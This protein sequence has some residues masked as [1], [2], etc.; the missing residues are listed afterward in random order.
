MKNATKITVASSILAALASG[1]VFAQASVQ[2][3]EFT[4]SFTGEVLR[5]ALPLDFFRAAKVAKCPNGADAAFS[6]GIMKC[7]VDVAHFA[8]VVCGNTAAFPDYVAIAS[9]ANA[10]ERDVCTANTP[11]GNQINSSTNLAETKQEFKCD[12]G[13]T[14]ANHSTGR[15]CLNPGVSISQN[16]ALSGFSEGRNR[17]YY[18]PTA[19]TVN[20][21]VRGT[22]YEV[23][24]PGG[25]RGE[26]S[27]VAGVA[28]ANVSEQGWRLDVSQPGATDKFKRIVKR[29]VDPILVNP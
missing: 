3:R 25:V 15:I 9:G 24:P 10:N 13:D 8:N 18:R 6:A 21:F 14:L 1:A 23:V 16:T 27:Y 12:V 29:S 22:D 11:A 7:S 20:R 26:F 5:G 17:D 4:R 19:S 28:K 2:P